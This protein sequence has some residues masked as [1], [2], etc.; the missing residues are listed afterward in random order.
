M[1][2]TPNPAL[3]II[4]VQ[5]A[6]D[7][8]STLKRS[9]PDME[10]QLSGTLKQWRQ[11]KLPVIHVRHSSKFANSPYHSSS[12]FYGFKEM[13]KPLA[14]ET[15]ITKKENTAFVRTELDKTLKSMGV[16][17]LVVCGVLTNHSI[18]ATIRTGAALGYSIFLPS[19]L[20]AAG[21]ITLLDGEVIDAEEVQ[22]ITLGN[23][24]EEYCSVCHASELFG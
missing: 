10:K 14:E 7:H 12:A 22:K 19:N 16:K 3:I 15:V 24:H 8:F 6:I 11:K 2:S 13:V 20:T 18:D 23:L 9:N 21:A 5:Q 17:E 1:L 4:D